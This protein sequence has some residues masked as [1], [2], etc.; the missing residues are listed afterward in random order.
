MKRNLLFALAAC[1]AAGVANA[2]EVRGMS[3]GVGLLDTTISMDDTDGDIGT[4]GFKVFGAYRF[5]RNVAVELA[6]MDGGEE[7]Q[8]DG[9][10]SA[11][12]GTNALQAS[13]LATWPIG[14]TFALYGRLGL[15]DWDVDVSISDGVD[16]FSGTDSGNDLSYGLGA[17]LSFSRAQLRLEY[18]M[19]EMNIVDVELL[20]LSA[21][22][23]F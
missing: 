6:Y 10:F 14:D 2:D 15:M 21:A 4:N 8:S 12:L 22:W 1:C 7:R 18:E 20:S 13:V 11:E 9:V 16:T 19:A 3:F 5:S 17:Q 23:L